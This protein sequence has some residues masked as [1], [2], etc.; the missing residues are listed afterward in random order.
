VTNYSCRHYIDLGG[1]GFLNAAGIEGGE[2][3]EELRDLTRG[4]G[5]NIGGAKTGFATLDAELGL[6]GS[7]PGKKE[8][9]PR[10]PAETSSISYNMVLQCDVNLHPMRS[11]SSEDQPHPGVKDLICPWREGLFAADPAVKPRLQNV[12]K[13]GGRQQ[14]LADAFDSNGN[15]LP[16]RELPGK[17]ARVCTLIIASGLG[18]PAFKSTDQEPLR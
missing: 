18:G 8:W 9:K 3:S 15:D 11:H 16:G 17:A 1:D 12:R 14:I 7:W 6:Q 10:Q 4:F 13:H 5:G 2:P